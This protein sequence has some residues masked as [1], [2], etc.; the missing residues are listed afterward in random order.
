MKHSKIVATIGPAS[1][2]KIMLKKLAVAGADIFRLNFSHGTHDKHKDAIKHIRSISKELNRSIA[3]L[4][5]LQGPKL[6]TGTLKNGTPVTLKNGDSFTITNKH[7]PNGTKSMVST[8][9]KNLPK[10][11]KKG[12]RILINDGLLEIRVQKVTQTDVVTQVVVGGPLGEHKGINIPGQQA[13]TPSMTAKDKKD[14]KF[15]LANNIDYVALSFVRTADDIKKLRSIIKRDGSTTQ[16]IAKI[17]KPQAVENIDSILKVTDGIMVARGDLGVEIPQEEVPFVQKMLIEKAAMTH[18]LV[19]TA[20]QMLES[21]IEHPRPTRAEITDVANAI[22]DGSD[23]TMLSGETASGKYPLEAVKTMN[24]IA[25]N[26]GDSH[27]IRHFDNI[28]DPTRVNIPLA[29]ASAAYYSTVESQAKA[30]LVFTVSGST[31][32][33]MSKLRPVV[34]IIAATPNLDT[35]YRLSL[36]WNV[37]PIHTPYKHSTK[38]LIKIG[39]KEAIKKKLLQNGDT[40]IALIGDVA[41]AGITNEMKILKVDA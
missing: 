4:A 7:V 16:I 19:I 35:F 8:T 40:I 18:K 3:I 36:L 30:I 15:A 9:Y 10:D 41:N 28:Y 2:S 38:S 31:A 37:T 22:L 23:A 14:L 33:L 27:Y 34:P 6:R 39:E 26:S 1:D 24:T 29:A 20:T 11:V 13:N 17:E 5:D 12:D 32:I 21:M 25:V